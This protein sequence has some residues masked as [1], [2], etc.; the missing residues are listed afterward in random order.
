MT[1]SARAATSSMVSPPGHGPRQ[2]V[3]PGKLGADVGGQPALEAAVVPFLEV[4]V[5][6]RRVPE[7]RD[8]GRLG[9]AGQGA[10]QHQRKGMTGEPPPQRAGLGSAGL[11]QRDVGPS[12]VS[13]ESRPFGL[14]MSDQP[15]GGSRSRLAAAGHGQAGPRSTFGRNASAGSAAKYSRGRQPKIGARTTPGTCVIRVL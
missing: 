11:G 12:G 4:R 3:Q 2:I 9:G 1:R 7:A 13:A 14:A 15:E 10:G 5:A 6:D 8:V